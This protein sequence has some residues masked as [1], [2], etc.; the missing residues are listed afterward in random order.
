[1]KVELPEKPVSAA[2]HLLHRIATLEPGQWGGIQID[3]NI[4]QRRGLVLHDG[5]TSKMGLD[6]GVVWRHQ[7]D[8]RLAQT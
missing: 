7:G 3:G 2:M 8:D 6:V 4:A 1:V 5:A